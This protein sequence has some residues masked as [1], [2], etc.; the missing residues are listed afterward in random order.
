MSVLFIRYPGNASLTF[1]C[2]CCTETIVSIF[3]HGPSSRQCTA[4]RRR[5]MANNSRGAQRERSIQ[6][7][8]QGDVPVYADEGKGP[9][10]PSSSPK[11]LCSCLHAN[12]VICCLLFGWMSWSG[13]HGACFWHNDWLQSCGSPLR[14]PTAATIAP[15]Q[16]SITGKAS[17]GWG[18]CLWQWQPNW[19]P[20]L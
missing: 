13:A 20:L 12:T 19:D 2:T 3:P 9:P 5:G 6:P 10:F 11:G 1:S 15:Q 7:L 16:F 4:N 14:N 17:V 8:N 18:V